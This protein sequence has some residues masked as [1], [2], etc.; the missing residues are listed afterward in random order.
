M[1]VTND[2]ARQLRENE[3]ET[4]L[5]VIAAVMESDEFADLPMREAAPRVL[6]RVQHIYRVLESGQKTKAGGG[7]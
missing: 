1:Q 2:W 5:S 7:T 6:D 4:V 3:R